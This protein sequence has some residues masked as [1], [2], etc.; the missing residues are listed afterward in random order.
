[1]VDYSFCTLFALSP[2]IL[3]TILTITYGVAVTISTIVAQL[4]SVID[5]KTKFLKP[6]I[7]DVEMTT[8]CHPE[9]AVIIPCLLNS[10]SGERED[11]LIE[12]IKQ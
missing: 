5:M 12:V 9:I 3:L 7:S 4:I 6:E 11:L 1:M 8:L 10:W 2:L